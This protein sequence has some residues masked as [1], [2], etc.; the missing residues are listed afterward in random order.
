MSILER[1]DVMS[2]LNVAPDNLDSTGTP[3]NHGKDGFGQ[4]RSTDSQ[5]RGEIPRGGTKY[6]GVL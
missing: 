2:A 5:E 6:L 3:E 1:G 4:L